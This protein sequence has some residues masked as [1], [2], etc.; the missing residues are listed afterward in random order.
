MT[1]PID[2]S[3]EAVAKM[4]GGVTPGPW[5]VV[6]DRSTWGWVE[7]DGPSIK[8]ASPT[9]ATDL[10]DMDAQTRRAEARFIAYAREAVPA[11]A[12][13]RDA[14][15]ARVAELESDRDLL[16]LR[17]S[18]EGQIADTERARAEAAEAEN[19]RLRNV[20][21]RLSVTNRIRDLEVSDFTI[22]LAQESKP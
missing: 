20:I 3:A 16:S 14:L 8:I 18:Q 6:E 4:L 10:T 13:E 22:A 12:A 21:F 11:L 5:W 15:A 19:A 17:Y 1:N 2:T 7:V 9:A